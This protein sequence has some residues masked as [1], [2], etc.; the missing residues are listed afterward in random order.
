MS[1][2][3]IGN[4]QQWR[5]LIEIDWLG[6]YVK[7]WI[8]FNAW[9]RNVFPPSDKEWQIIEAIKDDEGDICTKI[10]NLLSGGSSLQKSFQSDIADLHNSLSVGK[11]IKSKGKRISFESIEDYKHAKNIKITK[12]KILYKIEIDRKKKERI[13]T[14]EDSSKAT[15]FDKTI[16]RKEER[17]DLDDIWF[18]GLSKAQ[19]STLNGLLEESKPIHNLLAS[20]SDNLDIGGFKFI[21]NINLISRAIIGTLYQLRNALFHGE[22]TPDSEAQKIYKPTYLILMSIIPRE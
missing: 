1:S 14:V 16:N 10:E 6:Q 5:R 21:N 18:D 9:Y 12:S 20:D 19:K 8:A 13:V 2:S 7:A 3:Y 15:I 17:G 4:E 11:G 22:I